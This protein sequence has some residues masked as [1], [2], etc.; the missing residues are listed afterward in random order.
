LSPAWLDIYITLWQSHH[1]NIIASM[2]L[3]HFRQDDSTPTLRHGQVASVALS[4]A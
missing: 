2:I 3:Q 4:L 1:D